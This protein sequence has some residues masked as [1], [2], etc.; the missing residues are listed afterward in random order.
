[1][2]WHDHAQQ[3]LDHIKAA[4]S[5]L[6]R[7]GVNDGSAQTSAVTQADYWRTRI[8]KVLALPD[9]PHHVV[10]QGSALVARLDRL[11]HA[12]SGTAGRS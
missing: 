3:E 2:T 10:E 7:R 11:D 6:E 1:M 8:R 5:Q 12:H 4:I 9:L